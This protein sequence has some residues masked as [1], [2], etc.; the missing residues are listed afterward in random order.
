MLPIVIGLVLALLNRSAEKGS[1]VDS[2]YIWLI[3]TCAI[4]VVLSLAALVVT[5]LSFGVLGWVAFALV[6]VWYVIRV[7][8]GFRAYLKQIPFANYESFLFG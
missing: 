1:W 4:G 8:N 6:W 2:H 3:R 7:V 5:F